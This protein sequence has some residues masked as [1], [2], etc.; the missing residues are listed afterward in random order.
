MKRTDRI[1]KRVY[2]GYTNNCLLAAWCMAGGYRYSKSRVSRYEVWHK[3][4]PNVKDGHDTVEQVMDRPFAR[5]YRDYAA[6]V[7]EANKRRRPRQMMATPKFTGH[8]TLNMWSW[9]GICHS[10]AVIDTPQGHVIKDPS[11]PDGRIYTSYAEYKRLNACR[12]T[13]VTFVEVT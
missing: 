5:Y 9:G 3:A 13:M 2:Q 7:N 6:A 12:P 8:G 11:D 1:G 10:V 4:N